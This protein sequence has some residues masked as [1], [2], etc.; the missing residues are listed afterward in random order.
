MLD[1]RTMRRALPKRLRTALYDRS[2]SRRRRWRRTPGVTHVPAAAGVALTF[3][4]GPDDEY[5]P[6]L[7]NALDEIGAKATFFVVGER[8]AASEQLA[9]ELCDRGHEVGLHGMTHRR[10]D[11]L[12]PEEARAELTR[13]TAEIEG[14]TGRRPRRYRPPFGASSPLLGLL[15]AELGLEMD[16]WSAWGH[17][18]EPHSADRIARLVLRDMRAGSIVLLHDSPLYAEREDARP[19][20]DALATI[21]SAARREG[22]D[23]VSLEAALDDGG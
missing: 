13:G 23:L 16:Y 15:C 7:L 18:W 11:R 6:L 12:D 10:H 8:V 17:D 20:V 3:D 21:A 14:A 4:D 1:R 5:T 2:P 22:L 19:T 9:R